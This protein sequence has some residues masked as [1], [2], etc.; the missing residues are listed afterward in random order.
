MRTEHCKWIGAARGKECVQLHT[1]RIGWLSPWWGRFFGA[2]GSI[3]A[4]SRTRTNGR[5]GR[6]FRNLGGNARLERET[7][8]V[9]ESL[10]PNSTGTQELHIVPYW[11]AT[12]SRHPERRV[13]CT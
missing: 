4:E 7:Y 1:E 3:L 9:I 13:V 11:Q 2:H 6:T 12:K 10:L 5:K 8:L